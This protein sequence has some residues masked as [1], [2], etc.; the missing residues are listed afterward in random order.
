MYGGGYFALSDVKRAG[1]VVQM[2]PLR[3][4]KNY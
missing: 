1:M 4:L 3:N 2:L